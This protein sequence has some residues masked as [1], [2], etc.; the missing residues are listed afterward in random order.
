ML[1]EVH[2][3]QHLSNSLPCASELLLEHMLRKETLCI[4]QPYG[5]LSH[6]HWCLP[7]RLCVLHAR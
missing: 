1:N 5:S 2:F 3:E 7:Q 6:W 4:N